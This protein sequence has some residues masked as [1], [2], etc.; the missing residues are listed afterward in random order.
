MKCGV[1]MLTRQRVG[2][3]YGKFESEGKVTVEFVYEPPQENTE[4][5]FEIIED[6]K[7]EKVARLAEMLEV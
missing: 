1:I 7:E 2:Y 4:F 3:L 5:G 6:E